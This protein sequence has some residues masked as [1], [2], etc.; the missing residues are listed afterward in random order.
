MSAWNKWW[1]RLGAVLGAVVLSVFVPV[2]AWA[3]TGTGEV[4]VEAARRRRGGGGLGLLCC[5]VV[6]AVIVFLVYRL[7]RSRRSGPPR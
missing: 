4:V 1:G 7:V 5:L 6:L 3:S 2:A